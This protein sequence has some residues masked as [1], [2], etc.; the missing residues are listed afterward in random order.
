MLPDWREAGCDDV[1]AAGG[2]ERHDDA[3]RFRRVVLRTDAAALQNGGSDIAARQF[4]TK[5][6][7][8]FGQPFVVDNRAGA[9]GLIGMAPT[10][11]TPQKYGERIRKDYER[12]VRVIREVNIKVN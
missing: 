3:D 4:S 5:L 8:A 11:G 12:W 7:E 1:G 2:R 9:R 6:S 10:G